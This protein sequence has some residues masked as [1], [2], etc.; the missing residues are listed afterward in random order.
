M[1]EVK[2]DKCSC[3]E[4]LM[5]YANKTGNT[6]CNKC[7]IDNGNPYITW[8]VLKVIDGKI[9][10]E[11][12]AHII[13]SN[14][15]DGIET[16]NAQGMTALDIAKVN[17]LDEVVTAISEKSGV[18]DVKDDDEDAGFFSG[19]WSLFSFGNTDKIIKIAAPMGADTELLHKLCVNVSREGGMPTLMEEDSILAVVEELKKVNGS[20]GDATEQLISMIKDSC[21]DDSVMDDTVME[22]PSFMEGVVTFFSGGGRN[23]TYEHKKTLKETI[24]K[25]INKK[26]LLIGKKVVIMSDEER[27]P[28]KFVGILKR[29]VVSENKDISY[30]DAIAIIV[31]WSDKEIIAKV[32]EFS[33][34]VKKAVIELNDIETE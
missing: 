6:I 18:K 4:V 22:K 12:L 3:V 28:G 29:I 10:Q 11:R 20:D 23:E 30:D 27:T 14:D 33:K 34:Y 1:A 7:I 8:E 16:P 2:C 25:L 15:V 17:N 21:L 19:I 24:A 32:A 26:K 9:T 13:K 5:D 31:K